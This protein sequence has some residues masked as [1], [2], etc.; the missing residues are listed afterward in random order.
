[1]RSRWRLARLFTLL[2]LLYVTADFTDPLTPGVFF[3]EKG[4]LF[5]D[6]VVQFK[7]DVSTPLTPLRPMTPS[8]KPAGAHDDHAAAKA[9]AAVRRL[10]L[11]PVPWKNQK[12]DHSASSFASASPPDSAPTPSQS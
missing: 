5:V 8:G 3:I 12:H 7:S 2:L 11:E 10:R 1:M 9:H 4:A 6:G